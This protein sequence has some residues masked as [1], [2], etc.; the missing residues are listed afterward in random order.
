MTKCATTARKHNVCGIRVG[1][2]RATSNTAHVRPRRRA[3]A[4]GHDVRTP[5][6]LKVQINN[7]A[8]NIGAQTRS[9]RTATK[10]RRLPW[11]VANAD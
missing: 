7:A 5:G 9:Y 6:G 10:V 2:A 8:E 11:Y 1:V 3:T 4:T